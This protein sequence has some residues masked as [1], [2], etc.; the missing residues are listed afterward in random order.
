MKLVEQ[1]AVVSGIEVMLQP[2]SRREYAIVDRKT[3]TW[4]G[5]TTPGHRSRDRKSDRFDSLR[6]AF[7]IVRQVRQAYPN[8]TAV[9][10][11]R[12]IPHRTALGNDKP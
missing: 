3:G 11:V 9:C 6:E 1:W 4:R 2:S 10:L 8:A 7:D 5:W 12:L